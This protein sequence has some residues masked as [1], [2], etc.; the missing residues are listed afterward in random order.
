MVCNGDEVHRM[1]I[2][3]LDQT[4]CGGGEWRADFVKLISEPT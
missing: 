2:I 1:P 3:S 4:V